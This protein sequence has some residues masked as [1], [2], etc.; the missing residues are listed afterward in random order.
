MNRNMVFE[1]DKN[2]T[3]IA[4]IL[5][6]LMIHYLN[7]FPRGMENYN[8][9]K[10]L[11]YSI[12]GAFLIGLQPVIAN[13]RPV[14]IDAYIF[15]AVTA[16]L[17]AI[18]FL[19][20]Y[21]VERKKLKSLWNN[22]QQNNRYYLLLH[23]WKKKNNLILFI[24]IGIGF[25]FIPVLLY[26]GY[27][28]AGAIN[29]SLASKSEII[30]ALIFGYLVLKEKINK[31]QI[32]FCLVLFFGLI[33]AVTQGSLDLLELNLGVI[34]IISTVALFTIIHTL[35][36]ISL[37]KN[38]I[39]SS[40]VVFIRNLLSGVLLISTYFIFFPLNNVSI[41]LAPANYVYFILMGLDY[42]F[43][44]FTWYKA[45]TYFQIGRTTIVGSLTPI[46]TAF[47]SLLFLNETFTIFHLL[48][49]IIIIFA[50]I[51]II[52]VKPDK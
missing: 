42:G 34:I 41:L 14:S 15:G 9:K 5:I 40:Q 47:F 50:I 20:I 38:E 2:Q 27:A 44:L 13:S 17:E 33:L 21:L 3:I 22:S 29:S 26:I 31:F 45:L 30:F 43:S 7:S 28:L 6:P 18:I 12:I 49:T 51:M 52:R 23:G 48:G 36:K 46:V 19:P 37:E 10:G 11:F 32:I 39:F 8:F 1:Y 35:T 24:I 4:R 16:L 25:T